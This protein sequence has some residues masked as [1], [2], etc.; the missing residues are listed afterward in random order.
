[1]GIVLS[2]GRI[3]TSLDD[4][5]ADIRLEDEQI[6][7]IGQGICMPGD[8]VL[9]VDG[10]LLF[11]G[12]IDPHT[13]FDLPVGNTVTADDFSSGTKSAILGGTTTIIDFATQSHGE[14]LSLSLDNWHTKAKGN[15]YT[16]YGFHMAITEWNQAIAQEMDRLVREEGVSS[17]KFYLAYKDSLQVGDDVLLEALGKSKTNGALILVH[18]ENGDIVQQKVNE[19]LREGHSAPLYH[20]LT[21]PVIAERE[22]ATRAIALAEA[23]DAP[24]YIV[25]LTSE[26]ALQAVAAS[27][28]RGRKVYGETCPQYLL[29]DDSL[30]LDEGFQGAK[31]VMS[32][33][34]R[35]KTDQVALWRGLSSGILD[36][37]AT[38]HCSFNFKGQK[39]LGLLDFTKIPNGIPGVEHRLGLLYTYGVLPGRININQFVLLTSTRPA[40]LFG[41]FPRKG[42]IAVGSDADIVVWDPGA[43][44]VITAQ[45]QHQRVDYTPYEGFSLTGIPVHVFLRGRQVVSNKKL[46]NEHPKGVYLYRKPFCQRGEPGCTR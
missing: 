42:T 36:T 44:S 27:K 46:I 33:P 23:L 26:A 39:E 41:L 7:A 37:V 9:N 16:D 18:A 15:C 35:T 2:G 29:L 13:H 38:D 12:G 21:R 5:R 32:P 6:I 24:L 10:C 3:V 19:A 22:A 25:H 45:T 30:Y 11:P 20:A 31:Y 1:M 40:Q 8:E 4:Y 14:T 28:V 43:T 34:L 17:F